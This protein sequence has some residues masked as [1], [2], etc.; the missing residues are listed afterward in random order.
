MV[1]IVILEVLF[2][3]QELCWRKEKIVKILRI[4]VEKLSKSLKFIKILR[5]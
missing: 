1:V 3:S 5:G 4:I 2:K